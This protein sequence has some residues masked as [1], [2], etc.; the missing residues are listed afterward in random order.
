MCCTRLLAPGDGTAVLCW[1]LPVMIDVMMDNVDR[2]WGM[3]FYPVVG[4]AT[5]IIRT[6]ESL[7]GTRGS[8][9]NRRE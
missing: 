5:R 9:G 1:L 7:R 4:L 6:A 2:G 3:P 8:V